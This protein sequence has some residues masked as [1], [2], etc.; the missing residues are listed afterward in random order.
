[1]FRQIQS[2]TARAF[3]QYLAD[4]GAQCIPSVVKTVRSD[5]GGECAESFSAI[6]V[7]N[8]VK[9]RS[10]PP[11]NSPELNGA[12]VAI[13]EQ[14]VMADRIQAK[15]LYNVDVPTRMWAESYHWAA[16]ALNRS[17]TTYHGKPWQEVPR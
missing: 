3:E 1:M 4:V 16:G 15:V 7:G 9:E 2:D 5:G 6:C 14:A 11:A 12:A 10:I 13:V 17:A 8:A